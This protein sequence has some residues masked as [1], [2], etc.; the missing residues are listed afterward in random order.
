MSVCVAC[1][2]VCARVMNRATTPATTHEYLSVSPSGIPTLSPYL[3]DL[4]VVTP[5]FLLPCPQTT[6]FI[7]HHSGSYP[8]ECE[9]P[10][11]LGSLKSWKPPP[12]DATLDYLP[13]RVILWSSLQGLPPSYHLLFRIIYLLN[14]TAPEDIWHYSLKISHLGSSTSY[15]SLPLRKPNL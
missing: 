14:P 8:E 9:F 5:T 15:D 11:P 1:V 10:H 7:T 2:S 13:L 6:T 3:S 12:S 4:S